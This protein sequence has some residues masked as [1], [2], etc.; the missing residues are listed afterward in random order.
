MPKKTTQSTKDKEVQ[1]AAVNPMEALLSKSKSVHL[2]K[3]NEIEVRI[4]GKQI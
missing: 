4:E 2:K 3:G 1:T